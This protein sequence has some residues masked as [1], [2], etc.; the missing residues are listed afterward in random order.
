MKPPGRKKPLRSGDSATHAEFVE[1]ARGTI[2]F[3]RGKDDDFDPNEAP[4]ELRHL[5][6]FARRW[7]FADIGQQTVFIEYIKQNAPGEIKAFLAALAPHID[8]IGAWFNQLRQTHGAGAWP[9]AAYAF[10]NMIEMYAL[11]KPP[12][13]DLIAREKQKSIDYLRRLQKVDD[14]EASR[15]AMTRGDFAEVVRLL[16]QYESE[17]EGPDKRRLEIAQKR[18]C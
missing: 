11:V 13:P 18:V 1:R 6:P 2:D 9:A 12:N 16:A 8:E 14:L 15:T 4:L 17:L 10:L 5:I 3:E 7:S